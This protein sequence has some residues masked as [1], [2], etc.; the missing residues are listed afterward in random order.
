MRVGGPR[1]VQSGAWGL[2]LPL[3]DPISSPGR[4]AHTFLSLGSAET[5]LEFFRRSFTSTL[6]GNKGLSLKSGECGACGLWFLGSLD[7]SHRPQLSHHRTQT[8]GCP[9]QPGGSLRPGSGLGWAGPPSEVPVIPLWAW[10]LPVLS[11][12]PQKFCC[13]DRSLEAPSQQLE[14]QRS[15]SVVPQ[16]WVSTL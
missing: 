2:S 14:K 3:S 10:S 1:W 9:A 13:P 15:C 16:K 6:R 12:E 5:R 4:G 8:C 7:R 11:P